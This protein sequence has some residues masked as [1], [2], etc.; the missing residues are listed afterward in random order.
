ME[1]WV[2]SQDYVA[3]EIILRRPYNAFKADVHS[4]GVILYIM[5]TGELPF[6][7]KARY[8]DMEHGGYPRI[9]FAENCIASK[10]AKD[11]CLKM[12]LEDPA[13]RPSMFEVASNPWLK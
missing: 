3:P 4:L 12:L 6:S 2:G 5:L 10:A 7:R 9:A 8:A 1:N 13:K 11:L